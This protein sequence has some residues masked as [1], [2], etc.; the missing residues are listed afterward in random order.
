MIYFQLRR[1]EKEDR[2]KIEWNVSARAFHPREEKGEKKNHKLMEEGGTIE[3]YSKG[4]LMAINETKLSDKKA[5]RNIEKMHIQKKDVNQDRW[6]KNVN[7]Q[8]D[9][10]EETIDRRREESDRMRQ[11]IKEREEGM[12]RD[13]Q[14]IQELEQEVR[15]RKS[16]FFHAWKPAQGVTKNTE[17]EEQYMTIGE[18][19][20]L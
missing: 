15:R 18:D 20:R 9:K 5:E 6:E 7:K 2:T 16:D 10:E 3:L 11:I 4:G 19:G 17:E 14:R 1:K 8:K 12:A 13:R